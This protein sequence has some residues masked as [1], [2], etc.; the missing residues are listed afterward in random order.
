VSAEATGWVYRHSPYRGAAFSIH[1][2]VADSVNDQHGNEFW[3]AQG[4][5]ASKA[6]VGRQATNAAMAEMVIDGYLEI[7]EEGGGRSRPSHYRFLFPDA[8]V[9]HETRKLSPQATVSKLSS[10]ATVSP[11][12]TVASVAETVVQ[13]D[14]H[15]T[16]ENPKE[17][18]KKLFTPTSSLS[19][20]PEAKPGPKAKP[21][22]HPLVAPLVAHFAE[23]AD[24]SVLKSAISRI[25]AAVKRSLAAGAQPV[26]VREAL[27]KVL[28]DGNPAAF[29]R[30]L[31]GI[32]R[33]DANR[34][35]SPDTPLA[36]G[37][38]AIAAAAKAGDRWDGEGP[39]Q[40][41]G[42]IAAQFGLVGDQQ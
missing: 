3:M 15:R 39:P 23:Q 28:R 24:T 21:A 31:T 22:P 38:L 6:R 34:P 10:R 25:G 19:G 17:E 7:L 35:A 11:P 41:L 4:T 36:K 2:A 42:E 27:N 18:S 20:N 12:K 14:R 5:L 13:G 29:G 16:Q 33:R 1:L 26:Q 9:T 32:E 8:A 40:S 30:F 37:V